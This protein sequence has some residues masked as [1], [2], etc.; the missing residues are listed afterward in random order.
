MAKDNL[1][2]KAVNTY[3]SFSLFFFLYISISWSTSSL[4]SSCKCDSPLSYSGICNIYRGDMVHSHTAQ[5]QYINLSVADICGLQQLICC[6]IHW[7]RYIFSRK[8]LES[9]HHLQFPSLCMHLW[10]LLC[11]Q[12]VFNTDFGGWWVMYFHAYLTLCACMRAFLYICMCM[13]V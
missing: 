5:W 1:I 7:S 11:E 12:R 3:T 6:E 9:L 2:Y 13:W 8:R 10:R 4:K